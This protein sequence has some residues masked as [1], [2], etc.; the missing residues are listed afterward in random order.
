MP[1]AGIV[2]VL[3]AAAVVAC[4]VPLLSPLVGA[5]LLGAVALLDAVVSAAAALPAASVP[6]PAPTPGWLVAYPFALVLLRSKGARAR[7]AGAS[8]L[9][10]LVLLLLVPRGGPRGALEMSALD[11]GHGDAIVVTLPNGGVVL[12]DGGGLARSRFDTGERI[13]VPFLL[14]SGFRRIDAVVVSHEDYDHVG[15]LPSVLESLRASELWVGR[16]D[17][18]RPAYRRLLAVAESRAVPLRRLRSGQRLEMGGAVLHVLAAGESRGRT[19]NDR[20]VVL[21]VDY[22]GRSILLTG[23]AESELEREL[24]AA[25]ASLRADALKVAHH[26]SRTSTTPPFLGEVDPSVAVV[27]TRERAGRRLPSPEVLERLR[28]SRAVTLRTD[29][30][31]AVTLSIRADG[32]LWARTVAEPEPRRLLP[33]KRASPP[34]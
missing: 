22:A 15:G 8:V 7:T 27:S 3:A 31:G 26:G 4:D 1:L 25:G 23:D 12:V 20:S 18:A 21:K 29:R 28:R 34:D 16:P 33:P 10:V 17:E 24:V 6:V 32:S 19:A 2:C 11:V 9:A 30:R 13:V 14:D 5:T